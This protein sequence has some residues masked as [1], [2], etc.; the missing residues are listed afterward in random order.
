M[1][2]RGTLLERAP[3]PPSA[4]TRA[5][6]IGNHGSTVIADA[7]GL[8]VVERSA[9]E[10]VR[11]DGQGVR[12]AAL[13]L[14][15][16]PAGLG[17]IV[18]D[19]F[20]NVFVADRAGHRVLRIV[21]SENG[22]PR[23]VAAAELR[24]PFGLALSPDGAMLLVTNVADHELVAFATD[25]LRRD[26]ATALWRIE[27]A[28]E[29]RGV[30]VSA[31]GSKAAVGFLSSSAVAIVDLPSWGQ[32]IDW[33]SLDPSD[34]VVIE[35]APVHVTSKKYGAWEEPPPMVATVFIREARSRYRVAVETGRRYARNTWALAF[36]V[37]DA[38]V[39]AHQLAIPQLQRVPPSLRSDIY[40]GGISEARPMTYRLALLDELDAPTA[41]ARHIDV[42]LRQPRALAYD[43]TH[44]TLYIGGYG[45]DRVIAL[46]DATTQMPWVAWVAALDA[47]CGVDGLAIAEHTNGPIVWVHC[48]FHRQLRGLDLGD[49]DDPTDDAWLLGEELA[50]SLRGEQIE[51][52]AELFRRADER[53]SSAATL[54]CA[55][56]HPE[57]RSD[58]LTWRL[59]ASILQTPILAGRVG[60]TGPYKWDGQDPTLRDG[61]R[62]TIE[63]LG[64]R[65][66]DI[67]DAELDA[68]IAYIESLPSPVPLEAA[69]CEAV[70]RGRAVFEQAGCDACHLGPKLTDR[71]QHDLDTTL[72][73]VDTPSLLGLGHSA[74][75]FHDGSAINLLTLVSD[76]GSVHEMADT[77]AL[78]DAQLRDLVAYLESL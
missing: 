2:D 55:S 53:I 69:D 61:L 41:S 60:Q 54:A 8:L 3:P 68:L 33:R 9:G 5:A 58:G 15:D 64:G 6:H 26:G 39:V 43:A 73:H 74:P 20:G 59:G 16:Q 77:S 47:P 12:I 19:G 21:S 10:V 67:D 37:D 32:R 48:E 66:E 42:D 24:E 49:L 50:S 78:S 17:E 7:H 35:E 1:Q 46:A 72:T 75:Y 13:K 62:H 27:L 45:D 40:G 18:H 57:G 36:L 63:R 29:P 70:A 76:R 56:C 25:H 38:L 22:E 52:G 34:R 14:N 4:P 30:A 28:P 51:R 23:I 44:D 11:T 71:E 65:P 31:D